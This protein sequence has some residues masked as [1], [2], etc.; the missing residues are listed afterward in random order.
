MVVRQFDLVGCV[1]F[2]AEDEAPLVAHAYAV[3]ALS[4]ALQ[5]FQPVG[6]RCPQVPEV[7]GGGK[8]VEL[9]AQDPMDG[10]RNA[11][12]A[13]AGAIVVEL[14]QVRIPKLP[15]I[16]TFPLARRAL[17]RIASYRAITR[18]RR[19]HGPVRRLGLKAGRLRADRMAG[20]PGGDR[21]A[22]PRC[23]GP[24]MGPVHVHEGNRLAPGKGQPRRRGQKLPSFLHN[25]RLANFQGTVIMQLESG[26]GSHVQTETENR[27]PSGDG[28][29]K[30]NR[31]LA[32]LALLVLCLVAV[33][34]WALVLDRHTSVVRLDRPSCG[35]GQSGHH[36]RYPRDPGALVLRQRDDPER[37]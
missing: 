12:G 15:N 20:V 35:P 11:P 4:A 30:R 13:S 5:G 18:G 6:R 17:Y 16:V 28:T 14:L 36:A 24:T 32:I 19:C 22:P 2:P 23:H 27:Q 1:A 31:S 10:R 26:K 9:A 7:N 29:V 21:P 34:V 3:P 33:G 25:L 8:L 37:A